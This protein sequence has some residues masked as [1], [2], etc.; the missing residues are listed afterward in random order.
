MHKA[1]V[2]FGV[3][4]LS[5]YSLIAQSNSMSLVENR[6]QWPQHV[7]AGCDVVGGKVFLEQSAITFHVFDLAGMRS[8]HDVDLSQPRIRGHVYRVN[9]LKRLP[10]HSPSIFAQKKLSRSN[11]FL[12]SD[13]KQWAGGCSHYEEASLL[14]IYSGI[15][16]KMYCNGPFLKYDFII[17]PRAEVN[18]IEM[19]YEGQ[20]AIAIENERLV[21]STSIGDVTEQKPIAWQIIDGTKRFVSVRY[22]LKNNI[23]RFE[24]PKGYD[25]NYELIIDPELVFSTYSGSVSNNF[26]YTATYDQ[27]GA[28]YSGS[29]AFGQNYPT[30]LGAYD[31]SHNGGNSGIEQGI[32]IALTKYAPDGTAIEWSTFLGG[33]G[34]ELPHSIIVN[35]QDELIVYGSTGSFNFPTTPNAIDNTFGMGQLVSPTGTGASF[36]SGTDIIVSRFSFDG[37][38]LMG[39]TYLGGSGNDGICDATSLKYNYADEFRGEVEVDSEGNILIVSSTRSTNVLTENAVQSSNAGGQDALIGKLNPSLTDIL[40]LTY[41]GG[42]GDDSGFSVA[43][44]SSGEHFICGGTTSNALN[45]NNT[46]AQPLFGGTTDA[47]ILKLTSAGD[48]ISSGTYWG[49]TAYDQ[50][51]FIEIDNDEYVYIFGQTAEDA[52]LILNATYSN[53]NSGNLIAKFNP[54]LTS[55]IWSTVVGTGDNKPNLSP[56]AFLVDYCNRIYVSGWG[57]FSTGANSLNPGNN[58]HPMSNMPITPDAFDNSCSSG[59]FYMAVYDENMTMLEYATFFGGSSSGEHVDGGTSRFDKKGVIYQSVCAGCGG[60][61][62]FPIS[63]SDVVSTLNGTSIG[64]NNAVFK[65]DFQLPLTAANFQ[66]APSDCIGNATSFINSSTG[67]E[68][69]L[70]NFGDGATSTEEN[71]IHLYESAGTYT[72]TLTVQSATTCN[73][74]DSTQRTITITTPEQ[75]TLENTVFCGEENYV[76]SVP[77]NEGTFSWS[78]ADS[79]SNPNSSSTTYNGSESQSFIITQN[80]AGCITTYE[81]RVDIL[82]FTSI[83]NDTLLCYPTQLVLAAEFEPEQAHIIWS[84]SNN[85][86]LN[87]ILN[88][89]STDADIEISVADSITYYVQISLQGC[90]IEDSVEVML[91]NDSVHLDSDFTSCPNDTISIAVQNPLATSTYSW[92]PSNVIL[93]GQNSSTITAIIS[94]TTQFTVYSSSENGCSSSDSITVAVSSFNLE[95]ILVTPDTLLCEPAEILLQILE[96]P[97]NASISWSDSNDW[98]SNILLNDD[99]TD[100]DIII[101][102]TNSQVYFVQVVSDGCSFE[103]S[104]SVELVNDQTSL[105]ADTLICFKGTLEISIEQPSPNLTYSW[106]PEEV[107]LS[108]QNSANIVA[109]ISET[110]VITVNSVSEEGC[111]SEDSFTVFVSDLDSSIV[112]ANANPSV[113]IS[114]ETSQLSANPSGFD[115]SWNPSSSLN[116]STISNPIATP[117]ESTLYT[118]TVSDRSCSF[119][120][121]VTVKVLDVVCAP[122]NIYVPNAF[123]P[124]RDNRNEKIFV[125]GINI[126]EMNFKIFNRWGEQVFATTD[127]TIGWDGTFKGREVDPEVFVYYLEATCVGGENYFEKGNIT[128]IR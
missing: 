13:N 40:W 120:D 28:L 54:T 75:I 88:E 6:G 71:P 38:E 102:A 127:Q 41:F 116:S 87:T 89:D 37:S 68:S 36:P 123:T 118:L 96:T 119:S 85:W 128:V 64:C 103:E 70:W 91:A 69:Y 110:T 84:D 59:D 126:Q 124:N 65:F 61:D 11:Y 72:I 10:D 101:Q 53:P 62:D 73:G 44:N 23:V 63:S 55:T 49:G 78:P 98:G 109:D 2:I 111:V 46:A 30:T 67:A 9:F 48:S 99:S 107:I 122:P 82:K 15:D 5:F 58:L 121:T 29:S 80:N 22:A 90:A 113:I 18:Q 105:G 24:F 47:Y 8:D 43:E 66:C 112:S 3:L 21:V 19:E 51:Y 42:S 76:L 115:Y 34:D 60:L 108:G 45:W 20:S 56:T 81:L 79:L 93:S 94:E 117:L 100:A 92:I 125:R 77:S 7:V 104:V 33:S 31:V 97:A 57:V 12:G 39:S 95:N 114:G 32:D 106:S 35:Q 74:I 4:C 50:A 16:L 27:A 52:G 86:G 83:A 14:S 17:A 1:L 25:K 26:G